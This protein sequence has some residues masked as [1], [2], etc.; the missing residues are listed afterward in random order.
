MTD[1]NVELM[2]KSVKYKIN[3]HFI[4]FIKRSKI[5]LNQTT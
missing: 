2:I 5:H 1:E 4:Y 3:G